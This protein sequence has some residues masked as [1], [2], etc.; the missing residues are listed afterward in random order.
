MFPMEPQPESP[1][2]YRFLSPV[3]VV[4]RTLSSFPIPRADVALRA[5]FNKTW[6]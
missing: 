1:T 3:E 2:V 5:L 6:K 4:Y